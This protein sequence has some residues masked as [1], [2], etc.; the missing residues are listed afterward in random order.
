MP[1]RAPQEPGLG[2]CSPPSLSP[3][4][5]PAHSHPWLSPHPPFHLTL[6]TAPQG[7]GPAGAPGEGVAEPGLTKQISHCQG[8]Q[9]HLRPPVAVS[10][11]SPSLHKMKRGFPITPRAHDSPGVLGIAELGKF[12]FHCWAA[13]LMPLLLKVTLVSH[14]QGLS[15][16]SDLKMNV[17]C[18]FLLSSHP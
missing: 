4:P 18:S 16:S 3:A 13:F 14:F 5:T 10:T 8:L 12:T 11:I 2:A 1:K 7:K 9:S 17:I 6:V 15:A